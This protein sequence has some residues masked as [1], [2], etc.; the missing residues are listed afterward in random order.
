MSEISKTSSLLYETRNSITYLEVN[1]T[2]IIQEKIKR[3]KNNNFIPENFL[4]SF[5]IRRQ[6]K[7]C[8][9]NPQKKT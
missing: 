6:C 4:N 2:L 8:C 7:N 3:K 1:L 5:F 9:A